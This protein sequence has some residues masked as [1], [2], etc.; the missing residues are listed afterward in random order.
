MRL[1]V[2]FQN[3]QRGKFAVKYNW[4]CFGLVFRR[5]GVQDSLFGLGLFVMKAVRMSYI[6]ETSKDIKKKKK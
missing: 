6:G 5:S 3:N 1:G 4:M 2:I